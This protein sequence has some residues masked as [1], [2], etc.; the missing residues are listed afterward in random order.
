MYINKFMFAFVFV[1]LVGCASV[2]ITDVTCAGDADC[3]LATYCDSDL[4]RCVYDCRGDLDCEEGETCS[5]FSGRCLTPE[6]S[7]TDDRPV[8]FAELISGGIVNSSIT[9][10]GTFALLRLGAMENVVLHRLRASL[11]GATPASPLVGSA[12]THYMHELMVVS[13]STV[14]MGPVDLPASLAPLSDSSGEIVLEGDLYIRAGETIDL[15]VNVYYPPPGIEDAPG[16]F[17]TDVHYYAVTIGS[18]YAWFQAGDVTLAATGEALPVT[19]SWP[20]SGLSTIWVR[21]PNLH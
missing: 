1:V 17:A 12:G 14:V 8:I 18:G 13:S 3:E 11:S 2:G 4:R 15:I 21:D 9:S 6:P 5:V 10:G 7:P 20:A 16:E 19:R